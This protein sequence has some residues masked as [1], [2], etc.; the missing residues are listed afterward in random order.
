MKIH[1][2]ILGAIYLGITLLLALFI[3]VM[4]MASLDGAMR[5]AAAV[6]PII[7]ALLCW[8]GITGWGLWRLDGRFWLHGIL[9]ATI[10]MLVLNGLLLFADGG[11]FAHSTG[12]RIF[13]LVCMTIGLYTVVVLILPSGKKAFQKQQV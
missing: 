3:V 5:D 1:V 2:K 7:I 4:V 10:F 9:I 13:H 8:F 6:I 11:R 12:Q